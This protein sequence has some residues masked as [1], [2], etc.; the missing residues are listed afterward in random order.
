[1]SSARRPHSV[2]G[3]TA[4]T[5][6]FRQTVSELCNF[7]MNEHGYSRGRA[8][9]ALLREIVKES[10]QSDT[11]DETLSSV[12]RRHHLGRE[13]A[14]T[15]VQ[16]QQ[17][18]ARMAQK[19]GPAPALTALT[20]RLAQ[21]APRLVRPES[22]DAPAD[23]F[24]A[25]PSRMVPNI[26]PTPTTRTVAGDTKPPLANKKRTKNVAN[27][28]NNNKKTSTR[29]AVNNNKRMVEDDASRS[30][31]KRP[32]ADASMEAVA[33]KAPSTRN[34]TPSTRSSTRA[35]SPYKRSL[36]TSD[37]SNKRARNAGAS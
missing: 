24:T 37:S 27:I 18:V 5:S 19:E 4:A 34:S 32:R 9:A 26:R 36:D 8:T 11:C 21:A 13:E 29:S 16:V 20:Q 2:S 25:T 1:M 28:C 33:A 12:I 15:V 30:S 7:L 14:T 23:T 3:L 31:A 6:H 35:P 22:S 10:P 17:V